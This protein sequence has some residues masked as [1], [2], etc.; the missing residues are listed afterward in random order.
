M[1]QS[2]RNHRHQFRLLLPTIFSITT[3][4]ETKIFH[5]KNKLKHYLPRKPDLQKV[6][7]EEL[8]PMTLAILMKTEEINN[9]TPAK[10]KEG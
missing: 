3:D 2:L 9:L 4:G 8:Q 1:Q 6:L 7:K 10:P 5:D